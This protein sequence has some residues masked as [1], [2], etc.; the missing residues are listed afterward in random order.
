MTTR[1]RESTDSTDTGRQ[2]RRPPLTTAR[3][4]EILYRYGLLIVW[5]LI[6]ALFSAIEPSTFAT[7]GNVK[8]ILGTQSVALTLSL[9]LM[10][11][12]VVGQFDLSFAATMGTS[13]TLLAVLN[14]YH[15]WPILPC[16]ILAILVGPVVGFIN[17]V[18]V[19]RFEVNAFIATLGVGT[20]VTGIGYALSNYAVVPGISQSLISA[21][22]TNV[23]GIPLSFYYAI[24][25]AIIIW[26]FF[27][28]TP[29]GRRMLFAG[30]GSEVARLSGIPVRRLRMGAFVVSGLLGAIGGVLLAGTFG[31]ADPTSSS[32]YLLPAFAAC[33]LGS[34]AISPGEFNAG[35]TVIAVFFLITGVTGLELLGLQDWIQQVFYGAALILA[36]TLSS[37][38]SRRRVTTQST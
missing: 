26:Y 25:F 19:E 36:V 8:T 34:T 1:V 9:G 13:A 18:L 37:F 15:H 35:G 17:G 38:A 27:R 3:L 16:V 22:S 33:F 21:V 23:A 24:A 6:A 5:A 4:V 20:V 32:Q 30:D 2:R 12:L 11:P 10:L 7:V 31:S 29:T 14:A 28:Y